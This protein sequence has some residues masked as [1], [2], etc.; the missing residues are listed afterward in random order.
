MAPGNGNGV[1]HHR[2]DDAP[3]RPASLERARADEE[4]DR[5]RPG[6]HEAADGEDQ[7]PAEEDAL[8]ADPVEESERDLERGV[9]EQ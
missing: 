3:D 9:R 7:H 1:R 6:R 4:P 2:V 5:R 8:A